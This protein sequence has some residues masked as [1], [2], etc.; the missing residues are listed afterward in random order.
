MHLSLCPIFYILASSGQEH[1]LL[2]EAPSTLVSL[3]ED[4]R[5]ALVEPNSKSYQRTCVHQFVCQY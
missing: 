5:N 3:L 4:I 2:L 1:E